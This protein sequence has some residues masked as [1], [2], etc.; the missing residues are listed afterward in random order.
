LLALDWVSFSHQFSSLDG[1]Y[2]PECRSGHHHMGDN[3]RHI[4]PNQGVVDEN[5]RVHISNLFIAGSSVFLQAVTL[6]P[7]TIIA[8]AWYGWQMM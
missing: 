2:K 7:L 3:T 4:D 6:T 8:L 5:C 1:D